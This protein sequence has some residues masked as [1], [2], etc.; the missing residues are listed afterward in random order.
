M[1]MKLPFQL[2]MNG[3]GRLEEGRS[4]REWLGE[5]GERNMRREHR[6]NGG[7]DANPQTY[8]SGTLTTDEDVIRVDS[9][10]VVD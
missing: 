2:K 5:G 7:K 9:R 1:S 3:G 6:G 8:I 4:G 10:L